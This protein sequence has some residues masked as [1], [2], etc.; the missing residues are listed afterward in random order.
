MSLPNQGHLPLEWARLLSDT[1]AWTS[2]NV[3]TSWEKHSLIKNM[4]LLYWRIEAPWVKRSRDSF[5]SNDVSTDDHTIYWYGSQFQI[6]ILGVPLSSRVTL[7]KLLNLPPPCFAH[8]S[9]RD[10]AYCCWQNWVRWHMW[11]SWVGW[12]T[13]VRQTAASQIII[14]SLKCR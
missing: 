11:K 4:V 12:W 14:G 3:Q 10:S 8:Q 2:D 1:T 5:E 13:R 7:D 6:Q 9:D